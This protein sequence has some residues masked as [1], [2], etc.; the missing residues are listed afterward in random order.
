MNLA[1]IYI[2]AG[3][4]ARAKTEL[5]SLAKLGHK[6]PSSQEASALLKTL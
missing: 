4:K 3:D 1:K 6:D 2:P 5:E